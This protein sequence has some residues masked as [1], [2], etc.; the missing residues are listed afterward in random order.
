MKVLVVDDEV[1]LRRLIESSLRRWGYDVVVAS[2]GLEAKVI[3][4]QDNA[5]KLAVLDWLMPGLDGVQ[6]CRELRQSKSEDD[7]VYVLLLTAKQS[8]ND[9]V[10][11]LEAGADDYIAKPFDP[12]E[13]RVRLRA[14]KR[15]LYLLDQLTTARETMR[16]QAAR[17][18]DGSLESRRDHRA[19]S[20]RDQSLPTAGKLAGRGARGSGPFQED[21]RCP[22]SPGRR[23]GAVR[24][25]QN[26]VS[27]DP[28]IRC[29]WPHRWRRVPDGAPGM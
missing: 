1:V 15:I 7:Y 4:F 18:A 23:P 10:E 6:L 22:R 29:G 14:G 27:H 25:C 16:D 12:R 11:G 24:G 9:V 8:R 28:P 19:A 26:D 17:F 21:Q 13:L 3:L 20:E 5:P 2:D